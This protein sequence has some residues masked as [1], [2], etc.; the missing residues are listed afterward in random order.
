MIATIKGHVN[1]VKYLFQNG[2]DLNHVDKNDHSIFHLCA[3]YDR[4]DI[5]EVVQEFGIFENYHAFEF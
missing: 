2:A 3:Q 1:V 4:H 5:I